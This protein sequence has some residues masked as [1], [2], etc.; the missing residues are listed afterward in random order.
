M[1][2]AGKKLLLLL[3]A[4]VLTL[5][6]AVS[7]S[8]ASKVKLNKKTATVYVKQ[9]VTLKVEG[10]TK[11]V[12]WS[13][14]NKNVAKVSKTGKV[15]GVSAGKATIK[16]KI[17]KKTYTCKVTVKSDGLSQKKVTL[18]AGKSKTIKLYGTKIKS[19]SSSKKSVATISKSGK[20]TAKK[21]GKAKLT[22]KG[23]NGKKYTCTVTVVQK[24]TAVALDKTAVSVALGTTQSL[25]ASVLPEDANNRAVTWLSSNPAVAAVD[26]NGV[27]TGVGVGTADIVVTAADG[28]GVSAVCKVTVEAVASTPD[29]VG[30]ALAGAVAAGASQVTIRSDANAVFTVP[31]GNYPGITLVVNVPNG[32][33]VNEANF[34]QIVIQAISGNTYIEKASGNSIIYRPLDSSYQRIAGHLT[35]SANASAAVT[36]DSHNA[37]L[38]LEN[39]GSL[40]G[41][42]LNAPSNISITGENNSRIPVTATA[43][44]AG[45]N[46]VTD[47]NLSL[48]A[49]SRVNLTLQAG[50]ERTTATVTDNANIPNVSGLGSVTVT[51]TVT[52]DMETVVADNID[53]GGTTVTVSGKIENAVEEADLAGVSVYLIKYS[54]SIN[55][56]AIESYL[57]SAAASGVTGSDGSYSLKNVPIGNYYLVA[58]MNGFG[59]N[60]QTVT[61]TSVSGAEY[62]NGTIF[63][64]PAD[65]QGN[66]SISGNVYDA[67]YGAPVTYSVIVKV[68]RGQN[69]VSGAA[70]R[71]ITVEASAEGYYRFDDLPAGVYTVQVLNAPGNTEAVTATS[72]YTTVIAG[73]VSYLDITV[74]RTLDPGAMR[75]VLNWGD[76]ASGAPSDLD[77]HLVGPAG[78][79]SGRFHT[80]FADRNYD[81]DALLYDGLDHDDVDWVG[82]ETTTIYVKMN[83]I[84]SY[85]VYDYSNQSDGFSSEMSDKSNA[86][87]QIYEGDSPDPVTTVYIP[88]GKQGILWHVCDYNSVTGA[89]S[90]VNEVEFWI[91]DGGEGVGSGSVV[92]Y[93]RSQIADEIVTVQGLRDE[94]LKSTDEM[95]S[96]VSSLLSEAQALNNSSQDAQALYEMYDRLRSY[97]YT[98]NN[99]PTLE[100]RSVMDNAP[101]LTL[102]TETV[103]HVTEES[104]YVYFSVTPQEGGSYKLSSPDGSGYALYAAL[105]E[106]YQQYDWSYSDE[107]TGLNQIWYLEAGVRYVIRVNEQNMSAADTTITL[108]K[109]EELAAYDAA[110]ESLEIDLF[111]EEQV[112]EAADTEMADMPETEAAG[113][114]SET[115]ISEVTSE[116]DETSEIPE[117]DDADLENLEESPA[118]ANSAAVSEGT[119]E[120]AEESTDDV[121]T[122][123]PTAEESGTSDAAADDGEAAPLSDVQDDL[124]LIAE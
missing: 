24:A 83:G 26:G 97:R 4:V 44:A 68:R 121:D 12:K 82:P 71:T 119:D 13:S 27:V 8:A 57:G 19:V 76:E 48:T 45:S 5:G 88:K 111:A 102:G 14:S 39:N 95:Y 91:S 10:T 38:L 47:K 75:F 65:A 70:L 21:R 46:I 23:K 56:N 122:A 118:E 104:P 16:A 66:G 77:S 105:Y 36:L 11:K 20:I 99:L 110:Y 120:S 15:T 42:T 59:T 124:I 25:T 22:I 100:E 73:Q 34:R 72:D 32:E 9:S 103:V 79:G 64:V 1:K 3:F 58:V 51:N 37:S 116:A 84:Y 31:A 109:Y 18:D 96:E 53:N 78:D 90:V 115:E 17:G 94:R 54:S 49:E 7:A 29:Q 114:A 85:Y 123:E 87:V 41:L 63:M 28:S 92:E 89:L 86:F 50:A 40:S 35:I 112:A 81:Y 117:I 60:V 107:E 52:N 80:W 106:N 61:V 108:T 55:V 30:N 67:Y 93:L 74:T 98:L 33:V 2:K 113:E 62:S 6:M 101:Q 69:N 43:N